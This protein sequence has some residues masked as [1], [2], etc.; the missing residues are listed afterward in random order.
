[1]EEALDSAHV[2][3]AAHTGTALLTGHPSFPHLNISH[4]HTGHLNSQMQ[5][6]NF[7]KGVYE[8]LYNVLHYMQASKEQCSELLLFVFLALGNFSS[9]CN[10]F[11]GHI[12]ITATIYLNFRSTGRCFR[13]IEMNFGQIFVNLRNREIRK[14]NK[15]LLFQPDPLELN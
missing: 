13:Q 8:F 11:K 4:F 12:L 2:P 9:Y 1:M 5:S 3:W 14:F 15:T 6:I 10:K 7:K